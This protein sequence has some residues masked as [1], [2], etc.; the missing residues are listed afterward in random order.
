MPLYTP[1]IQLNEVSER[2]KGRGKIS[3]TKERVVDMNAKWSATQRPGKK[4]RDRYK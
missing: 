2:E 4:A 1:V 3:K